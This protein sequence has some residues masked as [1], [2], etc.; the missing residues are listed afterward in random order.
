MD[1]LRCRLTLHDS[2]YFATREMGTL[3]ETERFLHNYALSYALFNDRLIGVPY[4]S[5]SYR[6]DYPNDLGRLNAAR[7][8]VTPARP[9][10]WDFIFVTWK[11]A[12]VTYYRRPERFGGRGNYPENIGRA[13]ELAPGS[14]FEFFVLSEDSVQLPHWIRLGKWASKAEVVAERLPE[15]REREGAFVASSPLNP[16]DVPGRLVVY[17]VISMPPVSLVNAA[18]IQGRY[19]ELDGGKIRLPANMRYTFA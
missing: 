11:M 16:L 14:I 7:I 10:K 1:I 13:K 6:P 19:L 9:L 18:T 3:Y 4:F 17:D 12:Q 8:Y 2:L 5:G 15:V